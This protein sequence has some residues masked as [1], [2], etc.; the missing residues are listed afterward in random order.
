MDQADPKSPLASKGV[1]GGVV[2]LLGILAAA[3][4]L[5]VSEQTLEELAPLVVAGLGAIVGIIGRWTATRPIGRRQRGGAS[6]GSLV[7]CA[8]LAA[9]SF[10][11][12]AQEPGDRWTIRIDTFTPPLEGTEA[13]IEDRVA[14]V[15]LTWP[16]E[17]A[18]RDFAEHL[19]VMWWTRSRDR[20]A[21]RY[22]AQVVETN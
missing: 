4:G 14:L 10:G 21:V 1:L 18:C 6:V 13:V 11:A 22:C 20:Y 9:L 16:T 5:D 17:E 8:V 12:L 2:A 19:H 7:A 3:Y 15:W